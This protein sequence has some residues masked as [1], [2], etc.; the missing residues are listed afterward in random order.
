[1]REPMFTKRPMYTTVIVSMT[2]FHVGLLL[3]TLMKN[4]PLTLQFWNF[5]QFLM[6]A[7]IV[8]ILFI[9]ISMGIERWIRDERRTEGDV[10]RVTYLI[11]YLGFIA[12]AVPSLIG[13]LV[14]FKMSEN[15]FSKWISLSFLLFSSIYL[16]AQS[17]KRFQKAGEMVSDL[18]SGK[19]KSAE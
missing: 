2:L 8:P 14:V 10:F 1:M 7:I 6:E 18:I 9:L 12:S 16:F 17:Y 11:R 15:M 4:S 5:Y 3:L 13:L 19:N